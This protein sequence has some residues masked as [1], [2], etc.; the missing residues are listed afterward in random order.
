MTTLD[1]LAMGVPVV[2]WPGRTISSRLAASCLNAL[3]L[4]RFI[5][6]DAQSYAALAIATAKDL[7]ALASL[8]RE[9]PGRLAASAIGDASRYARAVEAAYREAWRRRCAQG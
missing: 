5:A 2:T 4:A 3:D 6:P 1:A 9:L 7:D 8:R